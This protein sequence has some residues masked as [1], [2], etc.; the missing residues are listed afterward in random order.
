VAVGFITYGQSTIKY[1]P[2]FAASLKAQTFKDF[3]V[4]VLDNSET[5]DRANETWLR[6]N[7]PEADIQ[8][9]P[10]N[11]GFAKAANQLL[12]KAKSHGAE[13]FWLLNPDTFLDEKALAELVKFMDERGKIAAASPKVLRWDFANKT[14]TKIIDTCGLILRLGFKFVDLGQ[15]E[16]DNNQFD[17]API[18]GPSGCS[19]FFRL[20][21]LG[22]LKFDENFFMY[23][24]DCDLAYQMFLAS[25]LSSLVPNALVWHD[26][27]V[28]SGARKN[29]G[30]QGKI[31]SF[32][33][34]H[35]LLKKYWRYQNF[36]SKLSIIA[37]EILMLGY[38]VIFEPYLL[39][40]L[41]KV[42]R[43]KL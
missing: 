25:R 21:A 24:E 42:K 6:Q 22:N 40:E 10:T 9:A 30:R 13:Y 27:T 36:W 28:A 38:V 33:G 41:S 26:R 16:I 7:M 37:R 23:K 17:E 4:L 39:K 1:L 34:Q 11:F 18:I 19:A 31:W 20:S 43:I 8:T 32:F 5:A 12:A 2:D 35:L 3:S 29:K 15:G 14:K